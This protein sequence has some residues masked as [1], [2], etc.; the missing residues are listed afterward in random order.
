MGGDMFYDEF[1]SLRMEIFAVIND[2]TW[3]FG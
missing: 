2:V 3:W 1:G